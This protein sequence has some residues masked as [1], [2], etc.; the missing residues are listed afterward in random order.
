[1]SKVAEQRMAARGHSKPT[2]EQF[3]KF[4]EV[5]KKIFE[6]LKKKNV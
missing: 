1:V 2:K 4:T 6:G 5:A 3:R